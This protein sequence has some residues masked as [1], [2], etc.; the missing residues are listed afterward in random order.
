MG[1]AGSINNWTNNPSLI[2]GEVFFK[3]DFEN[4]KN[5]EYD[6]AM[7]LNGNHVFTNECFFKHIGDDSL[8]N[9]L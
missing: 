1:I 9:K 2:K 8:I 6:F 5:F 4:I 7:K 3:C